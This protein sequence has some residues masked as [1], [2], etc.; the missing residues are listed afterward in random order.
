M[1]GKICSLLV[2]GV[3][4]GSL[5]AA[6]IGFDGISGSGAAIETGKSQLYLDLA[7]VSDTKVSFT[8]SNSGSEQCVISEIYF[9][10]TAYLKSI[11]QIDDSLDT[12]DFNAG[13][14][15]ADLPGGASFNPIFTANQSL[16]VSAKNP[17]PKNGVGPDEW[18]SVIFNLES[19]V[20]LDK[21][22][23]SITAGQTR[24][25][26]HVTS[27]ADGSSVSFIN[28]IPDQ[29]IPEPASLILIGAGSLL[30]LRCRKKG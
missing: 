23:N 7:M 12:V 15:P 2:M 14:K 6:Q 8:F 21:L 26:L 25:G 30:V 27:F 28:Q 5:S 3:M 20:T 9:D 13:A 17:S 24:V 19:G 16:S 18:V 29:E 1:F 22:M 11:Y 10:D 4:V